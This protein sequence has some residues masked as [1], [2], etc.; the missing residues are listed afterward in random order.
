[1]IAAL[2]DHYKKH[3]SSYTSICVNPSWVMVP[4]GIQKPHIAPK[5]TKHNNNSGDGRRLMIVFGFYYYF[6]FGLTKWLRSA[7]ASSLRECTNKDFCWIQS[8][9]CSSNWL[10]TLAAIW[11][12]PISTER[13]YGVW[14]VFSYGEKPPD[15]R[16]GHSEITRF[17]KTSILMQKNTVMVFDIHILCYSLA[18][19]ECVCEC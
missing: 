12:R 18:V 4:C 3:F 19:C 13:V 17:A 14:S 10:R 6:C 2:R 8:A 15:D 16:L 9:K 1:M 11:G 7:N 5:I